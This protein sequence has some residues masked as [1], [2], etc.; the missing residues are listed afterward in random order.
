[1][2]TITYHLAYKI[3]N[4]NSNTFSLQIKN[5]LQHIT[6]ESQNLHCDRILQTELI[7]T[8]NPVLAVLRIV[9]HRW[10]TNLQRATLFLITVVN[11]SLGTAFSTVQFC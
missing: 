6:T 3:R 2:P 1:M 7:A 4:Q 11:T 9:I 8:T 10:Q 5:S